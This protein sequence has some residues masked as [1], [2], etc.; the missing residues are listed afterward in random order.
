MRNLSK[1]RRIAD[2]IADSLKKAFPTYVVEVMTSRDFS[3]SNDHDFF[4][5]VRKDL[6]VDAHIW[7]T[8]R[9]KA[10]RETIEIQTPCLVHEYIDSNGEQ[11]FS[12][13]KWCEPKNMNHLAQL[14]D[15]AITDIQ[16][17]FEIY[18][19]SQSRSE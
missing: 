7:I 1:L 6:F 8:F 10:G 9:T 19:A 12:Q 14:M 15:I 3:I 5:Y 18:T 2:H 16:E 13:V 17:I 11:Q 4:V